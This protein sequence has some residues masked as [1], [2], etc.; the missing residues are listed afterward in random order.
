MLSTWLKSLLMV[1]TVLG[2]A[3]ATV[4]GETGYTSVPVDRVKDEVASRKSV[5]VDVREKTEWDK[6]HLE[7]AVLVPLSRLKAWERGGITPEEKAKLE[8]SLP[9]GSVVYCHCAA[10]RRALPGGEA[11]RK[12]GY[13]ARSLKLGFNALV[14]AGFPRAAGK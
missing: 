5:L 9:R 6:G 8:S 13:D 11:L 2:G 14:E 12:L 7:G 10:G 3:N 4:A 1:A